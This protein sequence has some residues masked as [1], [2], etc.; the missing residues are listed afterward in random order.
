MQPTKPKTTKQVSNP[1]MNLTSAQLN[2]MSEAL[3]LRFSIDFHQLNNPN[4]KSLEAVSSD[5]GFTPQAVTNY[6]AGKGSI[7]L[8]GLVK[9]FIVTNCELIPLW[10]E[11]Q[12]KEI[13]SRKRVK[14]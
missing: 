2:N 13:S 7:G 5:L 10:I 14:K 8:S 1:A 3:L 11:I 4:L 9:L 12:T 6:I